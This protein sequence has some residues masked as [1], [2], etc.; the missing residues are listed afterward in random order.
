M[1]S[2]P[3]IRDV[4]A[5]IMS[6]AFR[7]LVALS[8]I[9]GPGALF[10]WA[11]RSRRPVL[12]AAAAA[13]AAMVY[14]LALTQLIRPYCMLQGGMFSHGLFPRWPI[15]RRRRT[16][17]DP[18]DFS[19]F[20]P[21]VIAPGHSF[22]L[23]VWVHL[24]AQMLAVMELAQFVSSSKLVGL[25]AGVPVEL[26]TPIV[27]RLRLS[28]LDVLDDLD[29]VTWTGKPSNASFRIHVANDVTHTVHSGHLDVF[30]GGI[31]IA[32]VLFELA[33]RSGEP[34]SSQGPEPQT[35]LQSRLERLRTAFAS[36]SSSDRADVLGRIQGMKKIAPDLEVFLDALSLRSGDLW[37]S[38][39]AEEIISKDIFYL[40]WSRSAAE[41]TWVTKEWQHA[42]ANRGLAYI[43]PVPLEM[44]DVAP[45]PEALRALHFGDAF[46]TYAFLQ[47]RADQDKLNS[48][49]T[50]S[51]ED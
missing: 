49:T 3:D 21:Q 6:A 10:V 20:A 23:S 31:R 25:R 28:T 38:R 29:E 34:S 9:I 33:V 32:R 51:T 27:L 37:E 22:V 50:T 44:P 39:L 26:G 24:P 46:S 4:I 1:R 35:L 48:L 19:V 40:F 18:V 42:L 12:A 15:R 17:T 36:Y 47:R 5:A 43:D 45:P 13:M 16:A 41:S 2:W 7:L 30:T 8:T 14:I 11:V